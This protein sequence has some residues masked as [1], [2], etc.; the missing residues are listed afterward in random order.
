MRFLDRRSK[1]PDLFF[2]TQVFFIPCL[3]SFNLILPLSE[4]G[5]LSFSLCRDDRRDMLRPFH[6][7]GISYH[8]VRGAGHNPNRHHR[9]LYPGYGPQI[10]FHQIQNILHPTYYPTRALLQGYL[11]IPPLRWYTSSNPFFNIKE[12]AFSHRIPPVQNIATRLCL[13]GV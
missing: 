11:R 1:S 10:P 3:S 6:I 7:E 2:R 4:R 8:F 12:V 13:S 9:S 5:P